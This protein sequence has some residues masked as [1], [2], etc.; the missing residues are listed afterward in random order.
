M[1]EDGGKH[2][3][4]SKFLSLLL[5]HKPD[6]L[7]LNMDRK[8]FVEVEELIDKIRKV[9]GFGWVTLQDILNIIKGD[10]KGRFEIREIDRKNFIRAKY[11][12]SKNLDVNV[13]YPKLDRGKINYLYHGTNSKVLPWILREGLKPM[14]RKYV[15]LSPTPEDALVVSRRRRGKPVILK[16]DAKKYVEEGGEIWKATDKVYLVKEI[17]PK[18]IKIYKYGK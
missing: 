1:S 14:N 15:H 4:L 3:R 5:R 12:H 17:P 6:I 2:K 9:K 7:K 18:Y 16:I 10:K 8:G 11:G 13:C